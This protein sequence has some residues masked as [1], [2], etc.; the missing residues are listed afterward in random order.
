MK[1]TRFLRLSAISSGLACLLSGC[2]NLLNKNPEPPPPITGAE[3]GRYTPVPP[4]EK[5]PLP[6]VED[7]SPPPLKEPGPPVLQEKPRVKVPTAVPVPGKEGIV[8]S[9]FNNKPVDV[10]GFASGTLVADPT[11]PLEQKKYFRVP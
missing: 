10:K 4:E 5:K 11:F 6:P 2:I 1:G 3:T 9:P 7:P 8:F